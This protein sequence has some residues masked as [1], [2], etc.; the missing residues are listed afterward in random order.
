LRGLR[1]TG[2]MEVFLIGIGRFSTVGTPNS[3]PWPH[4]ACVYYPDFNGRGQGRV[5]IYVAGIVDSATEAVGILNTNSRNRNIAT[6][7]NGSGFGTGAVDDVG[8][9]NQAL[10]GAEVN[11]LLNGEEAVL[12]VSQT[13]GT[14]YVEEINETSDTFSVSLASA[15]SGDVN[16]TVPGS[17]DLSYNGGEP[18]DPVTLA[19]TVGNWDIP[20]TVTVTA[21]D[22]ADEEEQETVRL[23]LETS[24]S[25]GNFNN[26]FS[27]SLPV[28]VADDDAGGVFINAGDGIAVTEGDGADS[29]TVVLL[30][31]PSGDVTISMQ[32]TAEEP[33]QVTINGEDAIVEIVFTPA[34]WDT[35]Q[36]VA[37][38]AIDD[39]VKE[40]VQVT[41]TVRHDVASSD[42]DYNALSPYFASITTH[43]NDCGAGPFSQADLDQNCEVGLSDVLTLAAEFLGCSVEVCD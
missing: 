16:V 3:G 32:D 40:D 5:S 11:S 17:H 15:P 23:S 33:N 34:N 10:T 7:D 9:Y 8:I 12:R 13:D 37:I 30:S 35:P 25:D 38:E 39:A 19:F 22:D 29:Y 18:N 26:G 1:E 41:T 27:L 2:D 20:Q 36:T 31:Q 43:E 6:D 28:I 42:E 21:V 24:S 14:T 4:Y